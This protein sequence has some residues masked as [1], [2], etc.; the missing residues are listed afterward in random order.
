MNKIT[1]ITI[2]GIF[3]LT[4]GI[5]IARSI[6][7]QP[8][9]FTPRASNW[10]Q[11]VYSNAYKKAILKNLNKVEKESSIVKTGF[12]SF[13]TINGCLGCR[14]DRLT[15]SG[16]VLDDSKLTLAIPAQWRKDIPMGTMIK[17][18][19]LDNG[20]SVMAKANDTGGFLKY[21]RIADIS[22]ATCKAIDCK[23]DDSNVRLEYGMY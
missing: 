20:K 1:I 23:T 4:L 14:E 7:Y 8:K 5:L 17:V 12:V 10:K 13:Y 2:A 15:A 3:G 9:N 19:N 6:S 22:L 11:E 16:E 18:T 21:D